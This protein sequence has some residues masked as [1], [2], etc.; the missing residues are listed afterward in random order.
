MKVLIIA[1]YYPYPAYPSWGSVNERAACALNELCDGVA[2]LAP[3]PYALPVVSSWVPRWRSYRQIIGYEV[4]NRIPLYRPY[5]VHIPR[6]GGAIWTDPGAF[7]WCRHTVRDMHRLTRFD[8]LLSFDLVA[9]G[10]MAWRI[11]RDLGIP[12]SG[13]AIGNDVR[14]PASSSYGLVL[15][16]AIKH[17]DLVFYQSRE[18]LETVAAQLAIPPEQMSPKRHVV[19]PRGI[20]SPPLLPRVQVRNRIRAEWRITH[21][22]IVLLNIGR[23][24]RDKGIFE[25][26]QAI[27]FATARNPK[28]ICILVGSNPAFDETTAVQQKLHETPDLRERVRLLPHCSPDT[29]WE[30]LCAADIFAFP[31]HKEGMPNSLLEAMAMGVPAIAFAIPPVVEIAAATGCMV[32]VTPF[33]STLFSEAILRLAASPDERATLE[34]KGRAR[35]MQQFMIQAKMAE[36]LQRLAQ[37]VPKRIPVN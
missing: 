14:V 34:G 12:A 33:D 3:R 26:L 37:T 24:V 11:G 7:F 22:Q 21:D 25:L 27:A 31:S 28:I 1:P 9:S 10:G 20:P 17:L 2:V 5:Y 4:R 35:V 30:Y 13:W 8:A 29:V 18:L 36:A 15:R 19:L 32:A 16:R 23:M 6:L